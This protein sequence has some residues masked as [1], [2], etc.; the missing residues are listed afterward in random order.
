MHIRYLMML[1]D[2]YEYGQS[3]LFWQTW[4][5]LTA[6]FFGQPSAMENA[7]AHHADHPLLASIHNP[8]I[9]VRTQGISDDINHLLKL[10]PHEDWTAHPVA[11]S[12]R[13]CP[14][15]ALVEYI[16]RLRS[17]D[18]ES[19]Q[20]PQGQVKYIY[21][22]PAAS[23]YLLLSHAY[24]RYMGDLNG[25]QII[26]ESVAKAYDLEEGTSDGLRFYRFETEDG[27]EASPAELSKLASWFRKGI[28]IV[29]NQI[30]PEERGGCDLL[31]PFIL[32][33]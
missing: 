4:E 10:Q 23:P 15:S 28:D 19:G 21:P 2:I 1:Y 16:E 11:K 12:Y 24:V 6:C 7:L 27:Q 25:G 3:I 8:S 14:P 13:S 18:M 5:I 20:F 30:L 9:L 22:A 17:L 33:S 31:D 26:K 32:G 29:G